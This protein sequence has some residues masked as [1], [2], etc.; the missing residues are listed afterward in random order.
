[1]FR[2]DHEITDRM[3][4]FYKRGPNRFKILA[5]IT[6]LY[7]PVARSDLPRLLEEEPD[8]RW[9]SKP[10]IGR[11]YFCDATLMLKYGEGEDR[12]LALPGGYLGDGIEYPTFE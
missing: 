4:E 8:G 1:M 5:Y 12:F 9:K 7:S 11:G 10:N 3:L 2:A 6:R